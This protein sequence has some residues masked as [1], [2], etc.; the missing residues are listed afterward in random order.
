M[1]KTGLISVSNTSLYFFLL[2]YQEL[3][4]T[5]PA[6]EAHNFRHLKLLSF[7]PQMFY[8]QNMPVSFPQRHKKI[9]MFPSIRVAKILTKCPPPPP[10]TSHPSYQYKTPV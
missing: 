9:W 4:A 2:R 6:A 8:Q 10:D 1:S 3:V 7:L 5:V